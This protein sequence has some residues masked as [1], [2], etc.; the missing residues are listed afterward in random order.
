MLE[1]IKK[2]AIEEGRS[3]DTVDAMK[4]RLEQYRSY[5]ADVLPYY[6]AQ[7]IVQP[8]DGMRVV[9]EVTMQIEAALSDDIAA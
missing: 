7:N 8:I 1:R 2:R 3:D 4:V 6:Q 9:D 5:S